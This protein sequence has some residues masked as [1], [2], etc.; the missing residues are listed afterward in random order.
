MFI[1]CF[2]ARSR[3]SITFRLAIFRPYSACV[4][5]CLPALT[6]NDKT[7]KTIRLEEFLDRI[8]VR[9]IA[10]EANFHLKIFLRLK[11]LTSDMKY[12]LHTDENDRHAGGDNIQTGTCRHT[13]ARRCPNACG[14]R[15]SVHLMFA[16]NNDP[17]AE[18]PDARNDL[19]C[20]ACG[21][22]LFAAK[23]IF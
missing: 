11:K 10:H 13:N 23:T 6:F 7:I 5:N 4:I 19:R 16:V 15:Q 2:P 3:M 12:A 14:G 21:I 8:V 22:R 20:H 1:H 17:R 18:K 9:S